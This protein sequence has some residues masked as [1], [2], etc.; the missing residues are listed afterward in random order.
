MYLFGEI[1]DEIPNYIQNLRE[2]STYLGYGRCI[3]IV[4]PPFGWEHSQSMLVYH[5]H[6]FHAMKMTKTFFDLLKI[7]M[8]LEQCDYMSIHCHVNYLTKHRSLRRIICKLR[9]CR[10]LTAINF[11]MKLNQLK[12]KQ[13]Q[14]MT[15]T[16]KN[17]CSWTV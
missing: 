1:I 14:C 2:Y 6:R 4:F 10:K 12:L 11:F 16:G 8:D 3:A 17:P 9:I 5:E 15:R 13:T 7:H